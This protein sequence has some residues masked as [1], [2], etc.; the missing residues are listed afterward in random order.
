MTH[1]SKISEIHKQD[2]KT[3]LITPGSAHIFLTWVYCD[4]SYVTSISWYY[5][6]LFRLV[7]EVYS[8]F[9]A[10]FSGVF[11]CVQGI[12]LFSFSCYASASGI[13]CWY[14]ILSQ[15]LHIVQLR[16]T[17]IFEK[18]QNKF[19]FRNAFNFTDNLCCC[20]CLKFKDE[21]AFLGGFLIVL[22]QFG[23]YTFYFSSI[24]FLFCSTLGQH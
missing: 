24:I 6:L 8:G 13:Y 12:I 10:Q 19:Q 14:C 18:N 23:V 3:L 1:H 22:S 4:F 7:C 17:L 15:H 11:C 9:W 20:I 5:G 21:S 2:S 16:I